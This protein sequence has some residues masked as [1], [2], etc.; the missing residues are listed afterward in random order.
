MRLAQQ[1]T[2]QKEPDLRGSYGRAWKIPFD[3][4]L[5]P[6][7]LESWLVHIP[8]AHLL[9]EWY[10]VC[11]VHLRDVDGAPA[12][13]FQFPGATHE[14][15]I[16]ALSPEVPLPDLDAWGNAAFLTPID[17]AHQ[18]ILPEDGDASDMVGGMVKMMVLEGMSPDSDYRSYWTN[19][20]NNSSEHARLGEHP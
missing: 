4:D 19:L 3:R 7:A 20:L 13:N 2:P 1:N 16:L 9:W 8:G 17:L 15:I 10:E 12:P 18:V 11:A 5:N 14:F 6:A